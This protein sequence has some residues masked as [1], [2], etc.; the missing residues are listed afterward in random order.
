MQIESASQKGPRDSLNLT[1]LSVGAAQSRISLPPDPYFQA[2]CE[3]IALRRTL[4][5]T[6]PD[7]Q[8]DREE[9]NW[10]GVPRIVRQRADSGQ[11]ISPAYPEYSPKTWQERDVPYIPIE[12]SDAR[13]E[14]ERLRVNLLEEGGRFERYEKLNE[15]LDILTSN[16]AHVLANDKELLPPIEAF[17]ATNA[18]MISKISREFL[19]NMTPSI[20]TLGRHIFELSRQRFSATDIARR[21]GI[22]KSDQRFPDYLREPVTLE[23]AMA[24]VRNFFTIDEPSSPLHRAAI[25]AL[26]LLEQMPRIQER[27][28]YNQG[29]LS[30]CDSVEIDHIERT[31]QIT[32]FESPPRPY[33]TPDENQLSE[34]LRWEVW[35]DEGITCPGIKTLV[36]HMAELFLHSAPVSRRYGLAVI[37]ERYHSRGTDPE[38]PL[39]ANPCPIPTSIE[40]VSF[41]S[42]YHRHIKRKLLPAAREPSDILFR[43]PEFQSMALLSA[44][45]FMVPLRAVEMFAE[46]TQT[47]NRNK[48]ATQLSISDVVS[49]YLRTITGPLEQYVHEQ[50]SRYSRALSPSDV[51]S[52]FTFEH[53]VFSARHEQLSFRDLHD[54]YPRGDIPVLALEARRLIRN[55]QLCIPSIELTRAIMTVVYD[56]WYPDQYGGREPPMCN[57]TPADH[58]HT[59]LCQTLHTLCYLA[60]GIPDPSSAVESFSPDILPETPVNYQGVGRLYHWLRNSLPWILKKEGDLMWALDLQTATI[61]DSQ[62]SLYECLKMRMGVP[63]E[64]RPISVAD[65][66]LAF[67][68]SHYVVAI[69]SESKTAATV[70]QQSL[71][72]DQRSTI[73]SRIIENPTPNRATCSASLRAALRGLMYGKP[74]PYAFDDLKQIAPIENLNEMGMAGYMLMRDLTIEPCTLD[75]LRVEPGLLAWNERVSNPHAREA[76]RDS[77]FFNSVDSLGDFDLWAPYVSVK[78]AF[79]LERLFAHAIG[80]SSG[81]ALVREFLH[82]SH[83]LNVS[84]KDDPRL[85]E[86]L[87]LTPDVLA[88]TYR[89]L[90][91]ETQHTLA[92]EPSHLVVEKPL[93]TVLLSDA[94]KRNRSSSRL[95]TIDIVQ[96]HESSLA[97]GMAP[98]L[99]EWATPGSTSLPSRRKQRES[100]RGDSSFLKLFEFCDVIATNFIHPPVEYD[101]MFQKL[102]TSVSVALLRKLETPHYSIRN[103]LIGSDTFVASRDNLMYANHLLEALLD[104]VNGAYG[105]STWAQPEFKQQIW[106]ELNMD[107]LLKEVDSLFVEY[108]ALPETKNRRV[109]EFVPTRGLLMDFAGDI[110]G[111]CVSRL[112]FISENASEGFFIPF[113]RAGKTQNGDDRL[114]RPEGG[115][116]VFRGTLDDG[117]PTLVIRGFNPSHALMNEVSVGELFEQFA[118]YV[119]SCGK[120][121]GVPTVSI[122]ED[123]LWGNALT[124]RRYAFIY[125]KNTY[126]ASAPITLS[127]S[128]VSG[129]NDCSVSH[130][131]VVRG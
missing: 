13:A 47:A 87:S 85:E 66:I 113:V 65:L 80:R 23:E 10:Q 103:H 32:I 124:N 60:Q 2:V 46:A 102:C 119:A 126:E 4:L 99:P 61:T 50:R 95:S 57:V 49:T 116:F 62:S 25:G 5:A 26:M 11:G 104:A 67:Q 129:F 89:D 125:L 37:K 123:P 121:G 72:P 71:R 101:P 109:I 39:N 107:G 74:E 52:H 55:G 40:L 14:I 7:V 33:R 24:A 22:E 105:K 108:Q 17:L 35:W 64:P 98:P 77:S 128:Q 83:R 44:T 78:Q 8:P 115:A 73:I 30:E 82:A 90:I 18:D 94:L 97:S 56:T 93:D 1:E 92:A 117:R 131:K 9:N 41:D 130:V 96:L 86:L 58:A 118:D 36:R 19:D 91:R 31:A 69:A 79:K 54:T 45:N 48:N 28:P 88:A 34:F 38:D 21:Y 63:E 53:H 127:P 100:L 27:Y 15:L 114:K 120:Q 106:D 20:E 68:L 84:F 59:S 122:P 3:V 12:I 16:V 112:N 42:E 6:H 29:T 76:T 70:T 43:D 81:T 75:H 111:T 110:C 51:E